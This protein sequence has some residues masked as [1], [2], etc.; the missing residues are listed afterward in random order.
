MTMPVMQGILNVSMVNQIGYL[1]TVVAFRYIRC[2]GIVDDEG[3]AV[4][5]DVNGTVLY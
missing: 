4:Q 2:K 3:D 1:E 5:P